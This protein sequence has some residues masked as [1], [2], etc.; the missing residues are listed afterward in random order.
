MTLS[1]AYHAQWLIVVTTSHHVKHPVLYCASIEFHF[2]NLTPAYIT[3]SVILL[4]DY[5]LISG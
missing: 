3:I 2:I 4:F 5:L 1:Y